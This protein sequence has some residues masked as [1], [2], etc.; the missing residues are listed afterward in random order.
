MSPI[1]LLFR[2]EVGP[3]I[4]AQLLEKLDRIATM[5]LAAALNARYPGFYQIFVA[6]AP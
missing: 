2:F 3:A 5:P 6:G 1:I 4:L